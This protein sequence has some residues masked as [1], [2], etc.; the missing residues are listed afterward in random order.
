MTK[1]N[2]ELEREKE[3]AEDL[4][5]RSEAS[6]EET[7]EGGSDQDPSLADGT[8]EGF[9][10]FIAKTLTGQENKVAKALR[11]SIINHKRNEFFSKIVVPEETVVSNANG[12]KRTIKKKIYP[13]YVLIRMIMNND[14]WHLVNS[15]DKVTGFVGGNFNS[16]STTI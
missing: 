11:E 1:E 13:G 16:A 8:A 14:S 9:K 6:S 4:K 2:K 7:L 10:W 3:S 12:K 5:G 15:T